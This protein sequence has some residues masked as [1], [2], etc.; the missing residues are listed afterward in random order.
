MQKVLAVTWRKAFHEKQGVRLPEI[1]FG[2]AW[3][4]ASHLQYIFPNTSFYFPF[5]LVDPHH[6]LT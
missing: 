5:E 6:H 1:Y 3:A 4:S 2:H